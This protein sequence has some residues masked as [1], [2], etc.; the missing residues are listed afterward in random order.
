MRHSWTPL[1]L[2]PHKR[3]FPLNPGAAVGARGNFVI[4]EELAEYVHDDE[5][6]GVRE[7]GYGVRER[8][9]TVREA[10]QATCER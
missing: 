2:P 8:G 4:L 3:K 10:H 6:D 7:R 1:L 9:Y 5:R